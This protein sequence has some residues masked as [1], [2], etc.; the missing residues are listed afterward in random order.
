MDIVVIGK[1]GEELRVGDRVIITDFPSGTIAGELK[2]DKS[3]WAYCVKG[4]DDKRYLLM[5][6]LCVS[7][8]VD[9]VFRWDEIA[10]E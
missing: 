6:I 1:N 4:D 8:E 5:D 2:F 10:K 3:F 9:G 7:R